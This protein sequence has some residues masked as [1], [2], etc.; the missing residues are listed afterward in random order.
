MTVMTEDTP[1]DGY[2]RRVVRRIGWA[3]RDRFP[4]R[5][6]VREVQGVRMTLPWSHRLPDY[7]RY[8]P[9]YGQNLVELAKRLGAREDGP[10]AV[11]D[12]G[13]N[14]G[15]SALQI[16]DATDARVLCVEGDRVFLD[17][18]ERNAAGDP[19]IVVEA[20]LLAADEAAA[21]ASLAPVREGGTTHFVP[22][23]SAESAPGVA[24]STLRERHA[25]FDR[26]RL[27][28]SDTDGY[29]VQLV[30]AIAEAWTDSRP[31]LFFEYDHRLTRL[32]GLDPLPVWRRLA[33]LGYAEVAIWDNGGRPLKRLPIADVPAATASLERKVGRYGV[34]YW[35]VAVAHRDDADGLGVL[36]D[37]IP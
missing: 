19:R 24:P 37:L 18:L 4:N 7:A 28:K 23:E 21:A 30:P 35:D 1:P 2:A 32:A 27:A 12:V 5:P 13:A 9:L 25:D 36:A 11:L 3:V 22:G 29:D 34:R 26:L 10:L 17:F 8:N 16:L 6:V 15:D 20:A 14:V 33:D 31:V